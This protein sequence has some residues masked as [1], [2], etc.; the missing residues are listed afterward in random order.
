MDTYLVPAAAAEAQITEKRSRFLAFVRRV[1]SEEQAKSEAQ[2][3]KKKYF[4]ARHVCYAYRLGAEGETT[5]SSDDGEPSGTAGRPLLGQLQKA[6]VT[7]ALVIVVRYFGGVKL[8]TGPLAVAY[9]TAAAEAIAAAGVE[10]RIV[11]EALVCYTPYA[12]TDTAERYAREAQVE[13]TQR[14]YTDQG[15]QLHIAVRR[16]NAAALRERLAT[17]LSLRF[18]AE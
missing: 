11:S 2:A 18:I 15:V 1:E 10:E 13:I 14:D 8:G 3:F 16:D 4:D 12:D 9:K 5:R 6:E 7:Q 17:I